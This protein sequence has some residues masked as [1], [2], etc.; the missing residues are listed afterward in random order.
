M[1]INNNSLIINSLIIEHVHSFEIA[2]PCT[3]QIFEHTLQQ[4]ENIKSLLKSNFNDE[5]EKLFVDIKKKI[6]EI[7][8][9]SAQSLAE[10]VACQ[11]QIEDNLVSL[12]EMDAIM[13][14]PI[15][16]L[17]LESNLSIP[18]S[19]PISEFITSHLASAIS[20]QPMYT[21]PQQY[22]ENYYGPNSNE[23]EE[24][25]KSLNII[26]SV[27]SEYLCP[28]KPKPIQTKKKR[29]FIEP[30]S[31]INV[32]T[33][34]K[35]TINLESKLIKSKEEKLKDSLFNSDE[36]EIL[37]KRFFKICID[38]KNEF[39]YNWNSL[40]CENFICQKC[41]LK[42]YSI[43]VE[44]LGNINNKLNYDDCFS[45]TNNLHYCSFC[46]LLDEKENLIICDNLLC[47]QLFH[48]NCYK[49]NKILGLLK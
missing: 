10:S 18:F 38:C 5:I 17:N 16:N 32:K 23:N 4:I 28:S 44:M 6:V 42:Y 47:K 41:I 37:K 14:A 39:R 2:S 48:I 30:E 33:R 12:N 45:C 13:S 9:E 49:I 15:S 19:Q 26:S 34:S 8:E 43:L 25:I 36:K 7:K 3:K 40:C 35:N 1:N 27:S 29:N 21:I 31:F 22:I 24:F 46:L 11:I 20:E